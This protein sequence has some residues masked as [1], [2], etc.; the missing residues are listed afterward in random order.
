M[1]YQLAIY[2]TT[3]KE[4]VATILYPTTDSSAKEA[5]VAVRDPIHGTSIGQVRLRPVVFNTIEGLVLS[6]NTAHIV[7][8]RSAYARWMAFGA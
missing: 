6:A 2:A 7:R 5:R 8:Q 4:K 1:L 3:Q